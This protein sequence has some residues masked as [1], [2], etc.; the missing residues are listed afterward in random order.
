MDFSRLDQTHDLVSAPAWGPYSKKYA[1]ISHVPDLAGGLRF[2]FTVLPGF[3]R[4]KTLVPNVLFASDYYP[5]DANPSL[6]RLTYRYELE[7]K[8]RVYV[9]VTYS[10]LDAH[11]VLGAMHCVN[12]AALPQN[13]ALNLMASVDFPKEYPAVRAE[14]PPATA[15]INAVHYENLTRAHPRA[16][17]GLVFNGWMRA[18]ARGTDYLD[19]C[20]VAA[21][22]GAGAG[23]QVTYELGSNAPAAGVISLRYRLKDQSRQT[24]Q[25]SGVSHEKLNLTGTGK[26][27]LAELPFSATA[28][29][30][31]RLTLVSTGGS[32]IELNGFFIGSPADAGG[33]RIQPVA[34]QFTPEVQSPG[35][36]T[37]IL[38][39]ADISD[40][41]GISWNFS[42]A[43]VREFL[44]DDLDVFFRKSLQDHVD[45]VLT[46]N[47]LGH[48]ENAFL[49]PVEIPAGG[50]RTVYALLCNGSQADVR[51][52]TAA[53]VADASGFIA[54]EP[55]PDDP[56]AAILPAGRPYVFSQKMMRAAMLANLV[57]PVYT[58]KQYIRHFSPG[59]WWDSLYTWDEGFL[60][61]GLE[62]IN[63]DFATECLNAYTT[64]ADSQSAFI[65]HGSLVPTQIFAFFDLWNRTQSP[66][67]LRYF[68]PRLKRYYDFM[69]GKTG[70]STTRALPSNLLKTWDYFYNSGG[71]DDYPPQV[72]VH[73]HHQEKSVTP[74]V[75]TAQCIRFAKILRLSAQSLALDADVQ[76]YDHDIELFST[77]LQTDAWDAQSGYFSYVVHDAG[78]QP[79]NFLRTA[80]GQNY[81][82]G[83]DGAYPLVSGICTPEQ[84]A[85]LL[86]K[87]FSPTNLWTPSGIGAVD[88]S[89]S[90]YRNDGYWNG[91]VWMPHQWFL[92]KT[93][94][95]LGRPD[96]AWTIAHKALDVWKTET[97]ESYGVFE[98]FL[99]D[100]GRGAGWHQFTSLSAPVLNWF[101]AYFQPGTV[102]T[103]FEILLKQSEF[104]A[105][106]S[107]FEATLAFDQ[108]TAPH[109][110]SLLVCLN[111]DHDYQA[112][113]NGQKVDITSPF[114]GVLQLTLP[115]TN[116]GGKLIVTPA[117]Q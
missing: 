23:D 28:G 115:A 39:Y 54:R 12:R 84:Q 36:N 90:Y 65:S 114:R 78:G 101:A 112:A 43:V 48:Y 11:S 5:W 3:Y 66:E 83:L 6:T 96:L 111:P 89:A 117:G 18:E 4:F 73:L 8:D 106:R 85:I 108:A 69:A 45:R 50:E 32:G 100:S 56:F 19:G 13:L 74:V 88:Q 46:G 70:G 1:G 113:F 67:L 15:W 49:R 104:D 31:R 37:L 81:N 99:A 91:T 93:M 107:R 77:A 75:T 34:R 94:L 33:I 60:A 30:D 20:A 9:D 79:T 72:A 38:K 26:F 27:E 64:P 7:W 58:Q 55:Q 103:G 35:T 57:Y 47:K 41:Y 40:Y 86:A 110:R 17:D 42:P 80:D 76:A 10:L 59:K 68:Y 2:D 97:D 102:T 22:F 109:S 82:M 116:D 29:P 98:H 52:E 24:F 63:P 25:L 95:D 92:W 105:S 61:L 14:F 62:T 71:W 44:N 51:Q 21:G 87:I 53:F 16:D